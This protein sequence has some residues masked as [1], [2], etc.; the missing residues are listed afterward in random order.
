MRISLWAAIVLFQNCVQKKI[1]RAIQIARGGG[2]QYDT[3][4]IQKKNLKMSVCLEI[5]RDD[6]VELLK[7][8]V[9]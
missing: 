4:A 1:K 6:T 3:F 9:V 7:Q 8:T 5:D 2:G